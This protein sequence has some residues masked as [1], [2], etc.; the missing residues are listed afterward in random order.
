MWLTVI[1]IFCRG[2]L[3][4][5]VPAGYDDTEMQSLNNFTV[6]RSIILKLGMP[7]NAVQ[8]QTCLLVDNIL[9]YD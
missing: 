1:F 9:A 6:H 5:S 3:T 4:F 7:V 2:V 8:T